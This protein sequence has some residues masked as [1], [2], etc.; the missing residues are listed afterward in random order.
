MWCQ[1]TGSVPCAAL[2]SDAWG[3]EYVFGYVRHDGDLELLQ[4]G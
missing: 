3:D 4:R 2:H 1:R